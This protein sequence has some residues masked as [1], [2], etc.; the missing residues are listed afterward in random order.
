[1]GES[2][3]FNDIR[4]QLDP[5]SWMDQQTKGLLEHKKRFL[6]LV[7]AAVLMFG[8][9]LFIFLVLL[10][11]NH[12]IGSSNNI[13]KPSVT[14]DRNELMYRDM[15]ILKKQ[16]RMLLAGSFENKLNSIEHKIRSGKISSNDVVLVQ[17][18][19]NDFKILNNY[20]FNSPRYWD[21]ADYLKG[22]NTAGP[23]HQ[24]QSFGDSQATVLNE[25]SWLQN[26]IYAGVA[27]FGLLVTTVTGLWLENRYRIRR[28][29][30][31]LARSSVLL[32]NKP[33]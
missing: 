6:T 32:E 31:K 7:L 5:S 18:L 8:V 27:T 3:H 16:F 2:K 10:V 25:I 23:R 22:D 4:Y 14:M 24:Y 15:E 26:F 29:D 33:S 9:I 28:L 13:A 11:N 30:A 21:G 19:R 12:F 17:G 20:T 1:M